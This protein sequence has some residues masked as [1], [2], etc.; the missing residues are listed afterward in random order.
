[1]YT[2]CRF[3]SLIVYNLNMRYILDANALIYLVKSGLSQKFLKLL[4]DNVVIDSS[5]YEEVIEK[6]INNEYPDAH[7]AK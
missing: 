5:V 4:E 6:G 7:K 3:K 1:M 2:K